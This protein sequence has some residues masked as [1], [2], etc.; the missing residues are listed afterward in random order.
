MVVVF[1]LFRQK[2]VVVKAR[3]ECDRG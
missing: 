3:A 2:V 1:L